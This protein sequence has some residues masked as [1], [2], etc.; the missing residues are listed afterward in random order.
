[1][2]QKFFTL[3]MMLALVIVTGSAF[4]LN[5]AT[6]NPGGLYHYKV[7]GLAST[8]NATV[9]VDYVPTSGTDATVSLVTPTTLTGGAAAV[10]VTFDVTY[11]TVG[12]PADNGR[13]VVTV[14]DGVTSCSNYIQ[15]AI[16]VS[17]PPTWTLTITSNAPGGVYGCQQ[18][19]A[20]P[21]TNGS[22]DA[23]A[24]GDNTITY[25]VTAGAPPAGTPTFAY[26]I[27][28]TS[29]DF[30]VSCST[31]GAKTANGSFAATFPSLEGAGGTVTGTLS[32]YTFTMDAA[33]GGGTYPMTP[34]G[35]PL[36]VI[37]SPLPTIGAFGN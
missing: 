15:L 20:S 29:S 21:S 30:T 31:C 17:P 3:I 4:A 7:N 19:L 33:H 8:N 36:D 9:S 2:K 22:A 27:A 13:I 11:G 23:Y 12:T 18:A 32:G 16:T 5:E 37:V 26:T 28:A 24:G 34:S 35:S 10:S 14:Q 1:M 6:V 25:T